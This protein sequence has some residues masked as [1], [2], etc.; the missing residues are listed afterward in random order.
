VRWPESASET[1]SAP[2]ASE[3]G[4][5]QLASGRDSTQ[6]ASGRGSAARRRRMPLPRAETERSAPAMSTAMT[7]AESSGLLLGRRTTGSASSLNPGTR[8]PEADALGPLT[9]KGFLNLCLQFWW[10][11]Y[12]YP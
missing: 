6:P 9:L 3:R 1:D 12:L 4:W 5:T 2:P 10:Y 11:A 7:M 8:K